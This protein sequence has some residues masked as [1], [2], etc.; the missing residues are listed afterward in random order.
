MYEALKPGGK[1]L[2]HVINRDWI[3]K[4]FEPK[5]WFNI[6]DLKVLQSRTLDLATSTN[7]DTWHYVKDGVEKIHKSHIRM[8]AYH[9]M[10]VMFKKVGFVDIEGYRNIK[11]EPITINY[12]MMFIFGTKPK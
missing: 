5:G 3:V 11:E 10:I 2:L 6:G 8:Y 12:R 1:F 4:Y 7:H 9:E